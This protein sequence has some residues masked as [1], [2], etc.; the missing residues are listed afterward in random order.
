MSHERDFY[1]TGP[2]TGSGSNGGLSY[3]VRYYFRFRLKV[4]ESRDLNRCRCGPLYERRRLTH[5]D[6][7]TRDLNIGDGRPS[8]LRIRFDILRIGGRKR[9]VSK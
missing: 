9:Q 3:I 1:S 6:Q 5:T 7:S 4:V 8:L 2:S